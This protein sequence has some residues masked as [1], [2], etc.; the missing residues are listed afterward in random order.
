MCTCSVHNN[1]SS[2]VLHVPQV[3][4][5]I[6]VTQIQTAMTLLTTQ[7]VITMYAHAQ[8]GTISL[9]RRHALSVSH[10]TFL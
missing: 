6:P 2:I 4:L 9:A 7:Y 10:M 8:Q 1:M 5:V 3:S